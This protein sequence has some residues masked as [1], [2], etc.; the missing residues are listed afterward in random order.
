MTFGG[1]G[2]RAI[3]LASDVIA[4][5]QLLTTKVLFHEHVKEVL[6][7]CRSELYMLR[8]NLINRQNCG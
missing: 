3:L 6:A 8:R 1:G 5:Q 7:P 4:K 2:E